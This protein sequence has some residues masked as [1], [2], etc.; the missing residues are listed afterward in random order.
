MKLHPRHLPIWCIVLIV[1]SLVTFSACKDRTAIL[2]RDSS[3]SIAIERTGL[4]GEY[5]PSGLA[6]R[7]AKAL[8]ED[9]ILGGISTVYVAQNDS[10]IILKGTISN[11]TFLDR[12][13][14]IAQ[15]V[16]GVS[17]VDISLV[18]IR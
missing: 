14:T 12:L 1:T 18:E 9:S 5:D 4:D 16:P 13:V 10:N 17:E 6:K 2:V 8:A 3:P 7:V 11:K 15:N